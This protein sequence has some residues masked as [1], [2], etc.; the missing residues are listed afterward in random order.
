MGQKEDLRDESSLESLEERLH[1]ARMPTPGLVNE[2]IGAA[3]ALGAAAQTII[4]RMVEAGALTDAMLRL[5]EVELPQWRL[6]RLACE[7][8]QWYCTLSKQ[9]WL[10]FGLDEIVEANHEILPLAILMALIEARRVALLRAAST[11]AVPQIRPAKTYTLSCD[12]Y[13]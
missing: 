6:R 5:I 10:P 3:C 11:A 12:N 1:D 9:A 8:A 7:D 2:A 13:A 4:R